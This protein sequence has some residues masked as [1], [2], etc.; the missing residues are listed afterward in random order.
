MK[1]FL[2]EL[3]GKII[4]QIYFAVKLEDLYK[5]AKILDVDAAQLLNK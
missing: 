2:K 4:K 1:P 3:N 5:I